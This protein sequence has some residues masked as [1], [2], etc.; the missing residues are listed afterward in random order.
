MNDTSKDIEIRRN[1]MMAL[2]TPGER[3]RMVSSMFDTAKTLAEAGIKRNHHSLSRAQMRSQMFMRLYGES[4][5]AVE[6]A[7]MMR[8]I[9]EMQMDIS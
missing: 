3:I 7:R 1:R 4:F 2:K 6:I 9:P 5:S 8:N